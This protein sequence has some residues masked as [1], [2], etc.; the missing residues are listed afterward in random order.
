MGNRASA[1]RPGSIRLYYPLYGSAN[2]YADIYGG[3][4][5]NATGTITTVADPP[6]LRRPVNTLR[7]NFWPGIDALGWIPLPVTGKTLMGQIWM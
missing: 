7:A 3:Q 6:L 5:I 4:I 2:G 1:V